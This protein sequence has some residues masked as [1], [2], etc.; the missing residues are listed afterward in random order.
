M[1]GTS[2]NLRLLAFL[3]LL[4]FPFAARATWTP[5]GTPLVT[6]SGDQSRPRVVPDGS[7]GAYVVWEDE[8]SGFG[9]DIYAQRITPSGDVAYGWPA[10]GLVVCDAPGDQSNPVCINSDGHLLVAWEDQR[11]GTDRGIYAQGIRSHATRYEYWPASGLAVCTAP[12]DQLDPA[13]ATDGSGGFWA[14]WEDRRSD[15]EGDVYAIRFY[16]VGNRALGW[17]ENGVAVGGGIGRQRNPALAQGQGGEAFIAWQSYSTNPWSPGDVLMFGK[18]R[19]T[20]G[21][22]ANVYP[23]SGGNLSDPI[24]CP[25]GHGGTYLLWH[26]TSLRLTHFDSNGSTQAPWG[27]RPITASNVAQSNPVMAADARGVYVAWEELRNGSDR[28]VYVQRF[29]LATGFSWL[30]DGF[31]AGTTA[32]GDQVEPALVSDGILGV[33]VTWEDRRTGRAIR[34]QRFV[35]S[36]RVANGWP[37]GGLIASGSSADQQ[38]PAIVQS[39]PGVPIVVWE[40]GRGDDHDIYA[41]RFVSQ[42]LAM[43]GWISGGEGLCGSGWDQTGPLALS[44]GDHGA[45]VL[46]ID[47]RAGSADLYAHRVT[48]TGLPAPGWPFEGLPVCTA[49]GDETAPAIVSDGAGGALIAWEDTRGGSTADVYVQRVDSSGRTWGLNGVAACAAPGNQLDVRMVSDGAGGALL[50]WRDERSGGVSEL[51]AQHIT[52]SGEVAPGWIANGHALSAAIPDQLPTAALADGT[53]GM[54]VAWSETRDTGNPT[55]YTIRCTS[56]GSISPGWPSSGLAVCTDPGIQ[57]NPVLASDGG[58]GAIVAWLDMRVADLD[59]YA[60]H[61]LGSGMV[62]QAWPAGGA[63]LCTAPGHQIQL[64]IEPDGAGGAYAAWQD[65][66]AG[67]PTVFAQRVD[68]TGNRVEG[69]IADGV[70]LVAGPPSQTAPALLS[71][72]GGILLVWEDGR[73]ADFSPDLYAQILAPDGTAIWPNAVAV[74]SANASQRAPTLATDGWG[75]AILS[76]ED[77]RAGDKDVYVRHMSGDGLIGTDVEARLD[78]TILGV[79][80]P[81]PFRQTVRFLVQVP[82]RSYCTVEVIDVSGRRIH[83]QPIGWLSPGRR[84]LEWDGLDDRGRVQPAGIY[85]VRL[86]GAG[87]EATEKIVRLR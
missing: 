56:D 62:D 27:E 22:Y 64:R 79:V 46:W 78:N 16:E 2:R 8:R 55:V 33:F 31:P 87:V 50:T 44:D 30:F 21:Y 76:W 71:V 49:P 29:D 77:G 53:G 73:T 6:V 36:G 14:T 69:W 18:L 48:S 47:R 74:C 45:I 24:L 32:A 61:V 60:Q 67:S 34:V 42:D 12:G 4:C 85:F 10:D 25:D 57:M 5:D 40:D 58:N 83:E 23:G 15:P 68:A 65:A 66:R 9:K 13:L 72:A 43:S 39:A 19:S 82:H 1:S 7:G 26:S 41:T 20:S 63:A 51:F 17:A 86:R 75:G 54:F 81:N 28:D 70:P 84:L 52:S 35:S 37:V 3:C 80:G 11:S 38:R 59:I